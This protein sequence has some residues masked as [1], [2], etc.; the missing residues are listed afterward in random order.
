MKKYIFLFA[1]FALPSFTFISCGDEDADDTTHSELG[2]L[3]GTVWELS[4]VSVTSGYGH[5]DEQWWGNSQFINFADHV[6]LPYEKI[7]NQESV[8]TDTVSHESIAIHTLSFSKNA[9]S[10]TI[11]EH[12]TFILKETTTTYECYKFTPQDFILPNERYN[13]YVDTIRVTYESIKYLYNDYFMDEERFNIPLTNGIYYSQLNFSTK[14]LPDGHKSESQQTTFSN[15]RVE[16]T[17][18]IM[19][20]GDEIYSAQY[21]VTAGWLI[22]NMISPKKQEIGKFEI[23]KIK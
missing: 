16:P 17:S 11:D 10:W 12:T 21:D 2:S 14:D 6:G 15:L 4:E 9:C 20:K 7:E 13:E 23:K 18:F 3:E 22:L 1:A 5:V 8:V 19:Q